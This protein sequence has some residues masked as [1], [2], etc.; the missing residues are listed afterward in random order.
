MPSR[1]ENV[2]TRLSMNAKSSANQRPN[3]LKR[4]DCVLVELNS[5]QT[6]GTS[7]YS[8]YTTITISSVFDDRGFIGSLRLRVER[9]RGSAIS[10]HLRLR[11]AQLHD[12]GDHGRDDAHDD[13]DRR[14]VVE[15]LARE[16][17]VVRVHV[18]GE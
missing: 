7:V 11:A 18:G 14:G 1:N 9:A 5:S 4:P 6:S 16:R 17:E 15:L 3:E 8:A 12:V 2:A 10:A 13:G